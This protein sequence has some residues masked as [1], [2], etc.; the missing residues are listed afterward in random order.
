MFNRSVP[1]PPPIDPHLQN[2][3]GPL[4]IELPFWGLFGQAVLNI[5]GD[6]TIVASPW[7]NTALI[8]YI[9]EHVSL[10][11]GRRLIFSGKPGD[12]W[13]VFILNAIFALIGRFFHIALFII[14][15]ISLILYVVFLRWVCTN[16]RTAD[17]RTRIA[18]E[19]GS[20]GYIAWALFLFASIPTIIGWAWVMKL[21]W[22]WVFRKI[23]GTHTFEFTGTG[24][25][26]LWRTLVYILCSVLIIPIPWVMRWYLTWFISQIHISRT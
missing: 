17:N 13:F 26:L 5:I 11:D 12:I 9:F 14:I 6:L 10:P 22:Q 8:K 19:G 20:W 24:L 21:M 3:R 7:T 18:F 4:T 25:S 23:H 16:I 2:V 1:P 15:P